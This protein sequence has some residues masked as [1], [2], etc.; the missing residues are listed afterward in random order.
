VLEGRL[1]V[2]EIGGHLQKGITGVTGSPEWWGKAN[3][4]RNI[5]GGGI[6]TFLTDRDFRV[7]CPHEQGA[8]G[9][10][11]LPNFR[12][13]VGKWGMKQITALQLQWGLKQNIFYLLVRN[14]TR[15]YTQGEAQSQHRSTGYIC[16]TVN[17]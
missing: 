8:Q 1:F 12:G 2:R 9:L 13:Q 16:I 11:R 5:F 7:F 6:G 17:S 14:N 4:G 3:E 10:S 15:S